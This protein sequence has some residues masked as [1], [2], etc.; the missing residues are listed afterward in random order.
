MCFIVVGCNSD[1][2]KYLPYPL[3]LNYVTQWLRVTS[4]SLD[5]YVLMN[6]TLRGS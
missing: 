4:E 2:K 6:S 1:D 5:Q 3:Q